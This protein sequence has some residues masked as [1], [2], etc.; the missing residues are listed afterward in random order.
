[1]NPMLGKPV[2]CMVALVMGLTA[3]CGCKAK[4]PL[5]PH[6]Q[7]EQKRKE[8]EAAFRQERK[9]KEQEQVK[10]DQEIPDESAWPPA[11]RQAYVQLFQARFFE[12]AES[13]KALA[14][15]GHEAEPAIKY[16]IKHPRQPVNKRA[17]MSMLLLQMNLFRPKELAAY[18]REK[19]MPY[20]QRGAVEAL[21][22]LGNEETRQA[23]VQMVD[24]LQRGGEKERA[25]PPGGASAPQGKGQNPYQP[26]IDFVKEAM[27]Q[28]R[29]WNYS[30]AQL[31]VLDKLL[32][33]QNREVLQQ[34]L[35]EVK[36]LNL[37]RGLAAI[38]ESP[39]A[40]PATVAALL[41]V[42][43]DLAEKNQ[44]LHR[45]CGREHPSALRLAVAD[46][47]LKRQGAEAVTFLSKMASDKTD[48]LGPTL[49]DLL[50]RTA[51]LPGP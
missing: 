20:V 9:Q 36:D 4:Q 7:E 14:M 16:L 39:V 19:D 3:L 30:T 40:Q 48:P 2:V 51:R 32:H 46:R 26:L 6:E 1:M 5:L 50:I 33:A 8:Q 13:A 45:L 34:A 25:A 42:M 11:V 29:P 10:K 47:L 27:A 22:M 17:F 43:V 38:I 28:A 23:L 37:E 12:M 41:A 15:L 35:N 44:A 49:Q 24:A 31:E 18:L 21:A